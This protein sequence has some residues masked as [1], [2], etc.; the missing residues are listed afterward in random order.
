MDSSASGG[1]GTGGLSIVVPVYN[2]DPNIVRA[3]LDTALP[4]GW[5]L[6]VVDDGSSPA[7]PWATLRHEKRKGYGAAL[8]TG[9][10][11]AKTEYVAT[12]DGDGQHS[13]KDV[14][15]LWEFIQYFPENEMVIGDRRVKETES[16]RWIGR[17]ILN[18]IAGIFAWK[19]IPDLNS[20]LRVFRRETILGYESILCEGFSFTTTS[21]LSCLADGYLV[22]WLPI[23]VQPRKNGKSRV[24]V[25]SDGWKT[26]RLILWIGCA[27]RTRRLRALLRPL[28]IRWRSPELFEKGAKLEGH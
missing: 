18:G 5:E 17:K 7:C 23:R 4:P 11:A 15:R 16:H 25:W 28:W 12:M 19:F 21:T 13:L 1:K 10:R 27:L 26:L 24:K 8:K 9:I 20:G 6:I 3:L 22:D 2:E 14:N